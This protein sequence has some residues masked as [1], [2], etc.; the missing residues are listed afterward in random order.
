MEYQRSPLTPYPRGWFPVALSHE[1]PIGAVLPLH[2]FGRELVAFRTEDGKAHV[3]N[4]YCPHLGTHLGHGGTIEGTCIRCPFHGWKFDGESGDCVTIPYAKKIPP[5]A[6]LQPWPTHEVSGLVLVWFHE[7]GESPSWTVPELLVGDQESDWT[8]WKETRWKLA[9]RI[10]DL[11]ENDLDAAHL[12]VLHQFTAAIPE[13]TLDLAGPSLNVTMLIELNLETFGL[14]GTVRTPLHTRKHGLSIG[15]IRQTVD[16]GE[17]SISSRSI[18]CTTPIDQHSVDLRVLHSIR[19]T[20]MEQL[21]PLIEA[22]YFSTFRKAIDQDLTIWE[23]KAYLMRP[24][25]CE[26]DGPIGSFRK[27]SRQ[28]Y[29]EAEWTRAMNA[30]PASTSG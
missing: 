22:S 30:T 28:F 8:P 7:N 24:L 19:K 5:A 10:Q 17:F 20:G 21:D 29:D 1:L 23:H 18:G 9:A 12:P 3:K 4:A 26:G 6:R 11:T 2:Y 15:V 16:L 14:P 13:A 27:W 25:L